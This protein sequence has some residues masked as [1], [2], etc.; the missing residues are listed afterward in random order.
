MSNI[1]QKVI[2]A[3]DLGE[4]RTGLAL[5]HGFVAAPLGWLDYSKGDEFFEKIEKIV[6]EQDVSLLV[7]GLPLT[8]DG[9]ETNQSKW[10][11]EQAK[12]IE[13]KLSMQII[14]VEESYSSTEAMETLNSNRK[15]AKGDIDAYSAVSILQRYLNEGASEG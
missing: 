3:L 12:K 10:V 15:I 13:K 1:P 2:L 14:F 11:R 7:I 6:K 8:R 4:K 9:G 5:S